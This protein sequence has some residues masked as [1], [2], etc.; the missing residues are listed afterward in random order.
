MGVTVHFIDGGIDTGP[1]V[2]RRELPRVETHLSLDSVRDCLTALVNKSN[3]VG[4]DMVEVAPPYDS[5]EVTIGLASRLIVDV[6]AARFP[7]R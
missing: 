2:L 1:V 6:L 4:F 7:S 5:S 3:L